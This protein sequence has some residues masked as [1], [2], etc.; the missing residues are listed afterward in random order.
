MADR[1]PY[2]SDLTDTQ[3]ALIEGLMPPPAPTGR[4]RKVEFREV[5]NTILYQLRTGCQW[6]MLP[7]DLIPR[8]T[9]FTWFTI[10]KEDGTWE[11]IHAALRL[12]ERR[13]Q[14]RRDKASAAI[15]DSQSVK[16]P[17]GEERGYDGHKKVKGRKRHLLVDTMGLM[18]AC[19][20]TA[21]NVS[22]A[23]GL[24]QLV[25]QSPEMQQDI[26]VLFADKAY[27]RTKVTN[28]LKSQTKAR[29]E[30]KQ[31]PPDATGFVVV[32]KRWIVERSNAWNSGKRRLALDHES[33][34]SSARAWLYI[35][36][37][38]TMLRRYKT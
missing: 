3:W 11:Q 10:F 27:D 36:Q 4:P 28:T 19:V 35:S 30:L 37:I 24:Q 2:K 14:G 34:T 26:Q 16:A 33:T 20:I 38:D 8:S 6:D 18:L 22:D 23:Q 13:S 25:A 17:R 5:I 7:H 9:A 12:G 15:V 1:A 32:P 29:L 21:A 31:R